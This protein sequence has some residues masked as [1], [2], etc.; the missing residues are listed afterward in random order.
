MFA[1]ASLLAPLVIAFADPTP[2]PEDVKAGYPALFL[3]L[4]LLVVVGLLGWSLTRHLRRVE[5]NRRAGLFDDEPGASTLSSR[6]QEPS[7][8]DGQPGR[9]ATGGTPT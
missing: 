6:P 4:G 2:Q 3:F 7:A 5:T 9:P 8:H 1:P